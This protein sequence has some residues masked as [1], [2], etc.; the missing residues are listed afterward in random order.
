MFTIHYHISLLATS[1]Q[2]QRSLFD[3]LFKHAQ[4]IGKQNTATVSVGDVGPSGDVILQQTM[5]DILKA[6]QEKTPAEVSYCI[7]TSIAF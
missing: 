6:A 2:P 7:I 4:K 1:S 3:D 5:D